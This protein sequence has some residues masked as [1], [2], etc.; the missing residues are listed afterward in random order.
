MVHPN[1]DTSPTDLE[2]R[3]TAAALA[4]EEAMEGE[5]EEATAGVEALVEVAG[6]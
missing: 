5:G 3:A 4:E 6:T 1:L 2:T